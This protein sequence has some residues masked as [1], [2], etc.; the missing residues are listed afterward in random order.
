MRKI[1][2]GLT[3]LCVA[4]CGGSSGNVSIGEEIDP[5]AVVARLAEGQ[6]VLD[7]VIALPNTAFNAM[8]TTGSATFEGFAQINIDSDLSSNLDDIEVVGD[9]ELTA[10]FAGD[11]RVTGRIDNMIGAVGTP[12][13][14]GTIDTVDGE[15]LI[16]AD[17]SRIG[18]GALRPNQWEADYGGTITFAGDSYTLDDSIVGDFRGTRPGAE[19]DRVIRGTDAVDI[20]LASIGSG[21][22]AVYGIR[23]F[24]ESGG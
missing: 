7:R 18:T 17:F 11:G 5:D 9:S 4:A 16:G 10:Q 22:A 8:P 19:P 13:A 23:I 20:G 12:E 2:A 1:L 21:G 24:G 14:G 3:M 15:I 6:A